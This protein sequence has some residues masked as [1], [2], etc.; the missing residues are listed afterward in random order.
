MEKSTL[1]NKFL[2]IMAESVI[3]VVVWLVQ[4]EK[5][6]YIVVVFL[7]ILYKFTIQLP[8]LPSRFSRVQLCVTP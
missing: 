4:L 3:F 8:L 7:S 1:Q 6:M 5:Q 2:G